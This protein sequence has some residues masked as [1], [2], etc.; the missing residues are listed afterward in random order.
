MPAVRTDRNGP[1]HLHP[2]PLPDEVHGGQNG[3]PGIPLAA[4]GAA[5]PADAVQGPGGHLIAQPP[6]L[7]GQ[8]GR[9]CGDGQKLTCTDPRPAGPPEATG[10]ARDLFSAA[11]HLLKGPL[12]FQPAPGVAVGGE[13]RRPHHHMVLRAVGVAEG[14]FHHPADDG[15]R[16]G[17]SFSETQPEDA[18][19][20]LRMAVTAYIVALSAAGLAGLP[21]VADGALHVLIPGQVL[22]RCAADQAFLGIHGS[23]SSHFRRAAS[24]SGVWNQCSPPSVTVSSALCLRAYASAVRRGVMLSPL[25]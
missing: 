9:L 21:P 4:P 16:V 19:H 12:Q 25:P 20:P 10:P 3:Q 13:Q 2:E 23:L 22:Q 11:V 15:H 14:Q 1:R 17:G 18:V 24:C 8:W 7:L 6:R 5:H